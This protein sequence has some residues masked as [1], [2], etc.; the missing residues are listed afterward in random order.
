MQIMTF[1][2]CQ[3]KHIYSIQRI[4][5]IVASLVQVVNSVPSTGEGLGNKTI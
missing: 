1:C 5:L 4:A 2:P 3:L